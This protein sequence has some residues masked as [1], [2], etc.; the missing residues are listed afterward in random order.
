MKFSRQQ[1]Q[2]G[3]FLVSVAADS[4]AVNRVGL[5]SSWYRNNLDIL[6]SVKRVFDQPLAGVKNYETIGL[7]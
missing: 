1:P 4:L 6:A 3:L 7:P 5:V 2:I